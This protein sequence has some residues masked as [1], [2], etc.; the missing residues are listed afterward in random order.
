MDKFSV[1][2]AKYAMW[3]ELENLKDIYTQKSSNF[4]LLYHKLLMQI[5]ES[6]AKFLRTEIPPLSKLMKFFTSA[7]FRKEYRYEEFPDKTFV[8]LFIFCLKVRSRNEKMLHAEKLV[9][10]VLEKMD[11]FEINGWKLR[12]KVNTANI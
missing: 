1:E 2:L 3:D 6:Y 7:K 12:S 5:L 11:G 4:E 8:K 10:Y 9:K